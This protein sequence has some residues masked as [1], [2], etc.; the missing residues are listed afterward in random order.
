MS[1]R[2]HACVSQTGWPPTE[3]GVSLASRVD[4]Q[5]PTWLRRS[6]PDVLLP[7][8]RICP[9]RVGF[10]RALSSRCCGAFVAFAPGGGFPLGLSRQSAPKQISRPWVCE[11]QLLGLAAQ[12]LSTL[13]AGP[14]LVY[15]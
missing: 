14:Q 11:I 10:L 1:G 2:L 9:F 4:V 8:R 3:A 7:R 12:A 13:W 6:L 15:C 5:G